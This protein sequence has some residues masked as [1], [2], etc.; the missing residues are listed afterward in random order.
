MTAS[1]LVAQH[2]E[3]YAGDE[4]SHLDPACWDVPALLLD[5]WFFVVFL[6]FCALDILLWR[7]DYRKGLRMG[8]MPSSTS[9]FILAPP[10]CFL[11][12]T[13]CH[14]IHTNS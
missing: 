1:G 6:V 10:H 5:V 3:Y 8:S 7:F 12:A 13:D 9:S 4:N 11:A 14:S 2:F